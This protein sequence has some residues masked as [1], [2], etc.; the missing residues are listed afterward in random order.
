MNCLFQQQTQSLPSTR[1]VS[2][3]SSLSISE[4]ASRGEDLELSA[5]PKR[6]GLL[7]VPSI[8]NQDVNGY[9]EVSI[10]PRNTL[11]YHI[12]KQ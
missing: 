11:N 5:I 9:N 2:R 10:I 6:P 12:V 8:T 4:Y 1:A 3:A 7:R